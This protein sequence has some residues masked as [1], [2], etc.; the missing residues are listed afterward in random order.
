M[1]KATFRLTNKDQA[2]NAFTECYKRAQEL[3]A[4]GKVVVLEVK[5]ETRS[6]AQNRLLH[7]L[8]SDVSK[9]VEWAGGKRDVDTWKRLLTAAWL[10]TKGQSVEVLPA[11]DGVGVDIVFHKTSKMT[12]SDVSELCE[13][14]LAWAAD[15]GVIFTK[16]YL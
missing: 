7:S 6:E 1:D 8:L 15:A 4:L 3:I 12:R 14:I 10:R 5:G 13:F 9:Q 2:R 11:I 16:D